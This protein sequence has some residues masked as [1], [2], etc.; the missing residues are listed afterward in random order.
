MKL[1]ASVVAFFAYSCS[2]VCA[3]NVQQTVGAGQQAP[4]A[5]KSAVVDNF[6]SRQEAQQNWER[7]NPPSKSQ[8]AGGPSGDIGP[9]GANRPSGPAT[10]RRVVGGELPD[11]NLKSEK[12]DYPAE[13]IERVSPMDPVDIRKFEQLMYER[14]R[15]MAETPG[16][17]YTVKGSRIMPIS[18]EPNSRPGAID[19]AFNHGALVT[20]VDRAGSPLI[21]DGA[22]SFSYAFEVG[23][24]STDEVKERGSST[25]EV[26]A[27]SISGN[28]NMMIRLVGVPN[29]IL[30]QVR[31]GNDNK[32][33][34]SMI[35]AVVPVLTPSKSVL[36]GDR[37]EADGGTQVGEMQGFLMGI[38]PEGAVDVKVSQVATTSAWMWRGHLY[39][40]TPHTIFSPGWF[41]RQAAVDGTAVY[42]L[43]YTSLVRM[44]VDGRE[45]NAVLDLPYIPPVASAAR[46]K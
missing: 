15:A 39:V 40:R 32:S 3:Q 31:V 12:V 45:V 2:V 23:V 13:A 42:K 27:K 34:D 21:I 26:S 38:P 22:K 25:V 35:Q 28:G 43:P 14:A 9:A 29:P 33:V 17:P 5:G 6:P 19:I 11:P 37:L 10:G 24:L 46:L 8:V 1:K 4:A 44:G 41:N 7:T 30:L 16:G 18:F 20:F 36:P